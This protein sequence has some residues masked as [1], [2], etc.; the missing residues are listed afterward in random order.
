VTI[1]SSDSEA[2]GQRHEG[3]EPELDAHR[4][5]HVPGEE[6]VAKMD[7]LVCHPPETPDVLLGVAGGRQPSLYQIG[8]AWPRD[9]H[10]E[11]QERGE[12]CD[13]P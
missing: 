2:D 6:R 8:R 7:D 3:V 12:Q 1:V 9:H 4:R 11:D 13:V 10:P 5:G